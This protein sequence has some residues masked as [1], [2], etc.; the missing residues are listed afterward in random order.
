MK[1]RCVK[2]DCDVCTKL[3]SIQVFC[4]KGGEIK[5]A[6]ARH[7]KGRQNNKP[8]FGYHQQSLAYIQRKLN[9]MPKETYPNISNK[10][11]QVGQNANLDLEE[12]ESSTILM[13][14]WASSSVRIEHQPPKLG[15]EGSNPSPPAFSLLSTPISTYFF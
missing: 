9:E 8:K 11:G 3:D 4:N 15:V 13:K 12:A 7:Y 14:S 10:S 1:I 6:R 5:Y 2:L